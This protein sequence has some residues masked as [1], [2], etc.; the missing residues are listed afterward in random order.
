MTIIIYMQHNLKVK[1]NTAD[2]TRMTMDTRLG[3]L[4]DVCPIG[5]ES[6]A[7]ML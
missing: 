2:R 3:I 7:S 4:K 6:E 5:L 1:P